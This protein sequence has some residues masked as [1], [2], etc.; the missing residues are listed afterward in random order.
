MVFVVVFRNISLPCCTTMSLMFSLGNTSTLWKYTRTVIWLVV[1]LVEVKKVKS[2]FVWNSPKI[3]KERVWFCN[4]MWC[5]A[6]SSHYVIF[7]KGFFHE[8]SRMDRDSFV[9]IYNENVRPGQ[10]FLALSFSVVYRPLCNL[11]LNCDVQ[12]W[13]EVN[14]LLLP[15]SCWLLNAFRKSEKTKTD[16]EISGNQV[17][18]TFSEN[19]VY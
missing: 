16:F 9:K 5:V 14:L 6:F 7:F 1:N 11:E 4:F 18:F 13:S 10:W 2:L 19:Q 8:Q 17:W 3:F 15:F 12:L